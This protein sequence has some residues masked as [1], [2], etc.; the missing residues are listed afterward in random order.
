MENEITDPSTIEAFSKFLQYGPI[1]IAGLMLLLVIVSISIGSISAGKERILK[2]FMYVG[3]F[4]FVA[5]LVAQ[6]FVKTG[7]YPVDFVVAPNDFGTARVLPPPIIKVNGEIVKKNE[8]FMVRSRATA[9]VDVTDAI[10]FVRTAQEEFRQ[11]TAAFEDVLQQTEQLQTAVT[12]L[13]TSQNRPV[14][15]P[16]LSR[17]LSATSSLSSARTRAVTGMQNFSNQILP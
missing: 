6:A 15:T 13:R 7:E 8:T 17:V 14:S 3:A 11:Q 12:A 4:C 1:G 9:I 16:E 10:D 2:T 5:A